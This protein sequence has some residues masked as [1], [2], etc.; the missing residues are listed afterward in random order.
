LCYDFQQL[1][2]QLIH[3]VLI[4][5]PAGGSFHTEQDIA[6]GIK[7]GLD[8]VITTCRTVVRFAAA[9]PVLWRLEVGTKFAWRSE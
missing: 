1:V 4:G 2:D 6:Q 5:L 9:I 7:I 8:V 3:I